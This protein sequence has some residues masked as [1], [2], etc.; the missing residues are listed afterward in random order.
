MQDDNFIVKSNQDRCGISL[1]IKAFITCK[2]EPCSCFFCKIDF[3]GLSPFYKVEAVYTECS[4]KH[5]PNV[6]MLIGVKS[7]VTTCHI[8]NHYINTSVLL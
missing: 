3:L 6:M 8:I 7:V 2:T 4:M 1:L 5:V